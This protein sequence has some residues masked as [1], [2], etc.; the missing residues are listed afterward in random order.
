MLYQ[1][2]CL[3]QFTALR[4]PKDICKFQHGVS[5]PLLRHFDSFDHH[6][7]AECFWTRGSLQYCT[8]NGTVLHVGRN[9]SNTAVPHQHH[10]A[11]I[12]DVLRPDAT[13]RGT[14]PRRLQVSGH[15]EFFGRAGWR[16][17]GSRT[18]RPMPLCLSSGSE[19]I[20]CVFF[21]IVTVRML[22]GLLSW[23]I[24]TNVKYPVSL[25]IQIIVLESI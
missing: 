18:F 16:C 17:G 1:L 5:S 25:D 10:I 11:A 13:C 6:E 3:L 20:H 24:L 19:E 8:N 14:E 7:H 12:H 9:G 23:I 4:T 21:A 15:S 2:H 22:I